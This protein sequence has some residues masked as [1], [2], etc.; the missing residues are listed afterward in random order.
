MSSSNA[1]G[2]RSIR[3]TYLQL[4]IIYLQHIH[5]RSISDKMC[6]KCKDTAPE[7][8]K[9][10]L[11]RRYI[12]TERQQSSRLRRSDNWKI[13]G[14]WN[15]SWIRSRPISGR[16]DKMVTF[17]LNASSTIC[18]CNTIPCHNAGKA[19][20][21]QQMR[22][23]R[24]ARGHILQQAG[25]LQHQLSETSQPARIT[26]P[27]LHNGT[28]ASS[29]TNTTPCHSPKACLPP[30][31]KRQMTRQGSPSSPTAEAGRAA[32]PSTIGTCWM[33]ASKGSKIFCKGPTR[34]MTAQFHPPPLRSKSPQR[35]E[36]GA[37][38]S[39]LGN[40]RTSNR[41]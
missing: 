38:N 32:R 36:A 24:S 37:W 23:L 2:T 11:S 18:H 5:P 13:D 17:Q 6:R 28:D 7:L 40:P 27:N 20:R 15:R 14:D 35:R 10:W 21:V 16:K 9:G 39:S 3:T 1:R 34:W 4:L 41:G 22:P 29:R 19:A 26:L 30:E 8:V 25:L 31:D 12:V 33:R